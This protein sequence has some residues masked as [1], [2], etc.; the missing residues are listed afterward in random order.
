MHDLRLGGAADA[1]AGAV[2]AVDLFHVVQLAVKTV[3]DV[4]RRAVRDKY[5]RR[6][7]SG[8]PEY[9]VKNL[10]VR[11]LENLTPAQFAKIIETL[12]ADE[13]GQHR[14]GLDREGETARRAEPPRPRHRVRP[15]RAAGTGPPVRLLRLVRAE[16]GHPRAPQPR[17]H[18]L[19][20]GRR[21]RRSRPDRRHQR[22]LRK[23]Q[24]ARQARGPHGIRVPQP[25]QPA[26][27][28]RHIS[29]YCLHP[30]HPQET[31]THRNRQENTIRKQRATESRLS[32]QDPD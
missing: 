10:L 12:D 21:D 3:G 14:P 8:D 13:A 22:D 29:A 30:R 27:A 31:V 11:N 9:G 1:I 32:F 26:R 18:H 23:P 4:R 15:V 17:A 24:P 16:R 19:P 2:I 7:K 6:G 20:M 28:A 5:G 25:R